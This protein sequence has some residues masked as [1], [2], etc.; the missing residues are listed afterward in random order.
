MSSRS[1]QTKDEFNVLAHNDN[2]A[3][4]LQV[5]RPVHRRIHRAEYL[6][7][8]SPLY[9]LFTSSSQGV[10]LDDEGSGTVFHMKF[11]TAVT[12]HQGAEYRVR[13]YEDVTTDSELDTASPRN[14]NRRTG[15]TIGDV[16]FDARQSTLLAGTLLLDTLVP[17][18]EMFE[19]KEWIISNDSDNFA[20]LILIT[21]LSAITSFFATIGIDFYQAAGS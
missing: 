14:H 13:M 19:S 16:F 9:F 3:N 10:L 1:G 18:G 21:N 20:G 5:I 12:G 8:S 7:F 11:R 15:A 4:A 6:S 2:I 17:S